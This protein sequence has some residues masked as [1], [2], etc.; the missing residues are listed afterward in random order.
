MIRAFL[1]PSSSSIK[2][3][4]GLSNGGGAPP[5]GVGG[6]KNYLR[7]REPKDPCAALRST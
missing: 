3:G 1:F 7:L 5:T 4:R 6:P 2:F